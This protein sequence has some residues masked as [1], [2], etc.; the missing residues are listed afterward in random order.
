ME[1]GSGAQRPGAQQGLHAS[2]GA[3]P[4]CGAGGAT[5]KNVSLLILSQVLTYL[6][7]IPVFFFFFLII[8][9]VCLDLWDLSSPS[10]GTEPRLLAMKAQSPNDWTT[11]EFPHSGLTQKQNPT[12]DMI[13]ILFK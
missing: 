13:K 11:R 8:Y 1:Q 6:D 10:S 3:W 2:V 5:C 7:P 12:G 9:L 4:V